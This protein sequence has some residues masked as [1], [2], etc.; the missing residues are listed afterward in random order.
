[1]NLSPYYWAGVRWF[2]V[3]RVGWFGEP[4]A[5]RAAWMR[6]SAERR[7]RGSIS[8]NTCP[9]VSSV[10]VALWPAWRAMSMM[11]RPSAI[12]RETNEW[13][14]SYGRAPAAPADSAARRKRR[15]RQLRQASSGHGS[16]RAPGKTRALAEGSDDACRK[17]QRSS[18]SGASS[19]TDRVRRVFVS[20]N[21]PIDTACSTTIVRAPTAPQVKPRA[22]PG[23]RPAYAK[24][25]SSVAPAMSPRAARSS[26]ISSTTSG[27]SGL[28]TRR[29]CDGGFR[30][31]R[32]GLEA[33]Y[34]HSPSTAPRAGA[35]ALRARAIPA[36]V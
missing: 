7:S 30:T 10:I 12:R 4:K 21:C 16:P 18:R 6:S 32:I 9:Y 23:R 35:S 28:T 24:T 22:S 34:S 27:G 20:L 31:R 19:R 8:S 33:R 29:R 13:R 1:M 11:L 17:A 15:R 26:R 14:R 3:S 2:G 36:S 5:R 25:D